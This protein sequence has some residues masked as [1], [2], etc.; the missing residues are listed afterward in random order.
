MRAINL[1]SGNGWKQKSRVRPGAA[2]ALRRAG[3]SLQLQED[4]LGEGGGGWPGVGP[5]EASVPTH[6]GHLRHRADRETGVSLINQY[7]SSRPF[8]V[9]F[10]VFG[11]Q[12]F[13][14]SPGALGTN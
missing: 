14:V 7:V 3:D 8:V 4:G 9:D 5:G 10:E 6:H 1:I 13:S 12:D 11:P 2:N